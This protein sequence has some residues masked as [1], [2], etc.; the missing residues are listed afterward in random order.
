MTC[1]YYQKLGHREYECYKK[2]SDEQSGEPQDEKNH[3]KPAQPSGFTP[4]PRPN[5]NSGAD[6]K[7]HV[8]VINN[9]ETATASDVVI[10]NFFIYFMSTKVLFN[11]GASHSFISRTL[12]HKLKLESP[13]SISLDIT[14]P[15]GE[16]MSCTKMH[17]GVPLVISKVELSSN[18][19]ELDLQDHDVILGM[20]WLGKYKAQIDCE[21]QK[22]TLCGPDKVRVT[23]RRE[24]KKSGLKIISALQLK[25]CIA[26][27][28]PLYICSVQN[29]EEGDSDDGKNIP[30]VKEFLDVFPEEIPGMPPIRDVKFTID[31]VP[32]KILDFSVA[33]DGNM[34]FKG[35]WCVP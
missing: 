29:I 3:P 8:F 12:V 7:G 16:V 30:V 19:I 9:R 31:L 35:R 23:Y 34:R 17:Q 32:G 28:Y 20:D 21:A 14:I 24:G 26:K 25:K 15:S 2:V 5:N 22:V 4:K 11:L 18:L 33:D 27:G 10:G 13:V 1:R 6:P